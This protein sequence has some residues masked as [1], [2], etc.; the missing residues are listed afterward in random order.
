MGG[1]MPGFLGPIPSGVQILG[2]LPS[3]VSTKVRPEFSRIR[4]LVSDFARSWSFYRDDLGL[5][6]VPG[7]GQPPYGEFRTGRRAT[8]AVFDRAEMARSIGLPIRPPGGRATGPI[9][10]I[11]E[12][13]NVDDFARHLRSRKVPVLRGPTDRP[14][15]GLRTLHLVDPDRNLVEVY[16]SL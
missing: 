9:A 4:L 12:V 13:P 2:A 15:W 6:P 11:L 5:T 14:A 7:H 16:S 3:S 1:R 8:V 10:L